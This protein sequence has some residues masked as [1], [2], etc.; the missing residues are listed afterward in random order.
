VYRG[1]RGNPTIFSRR[2]YNQLLKIKG[3]MGGRGII[4]TYPN[5]V[6]YVEV[7][8]PS[9]LIDIDNQEDLEKLKTSAFAKSLI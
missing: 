3:D 4:Q 5:D 9:F 2:F 7:N 6:C 1:Q 8:D